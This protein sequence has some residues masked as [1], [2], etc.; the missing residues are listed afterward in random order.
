MKA[1]LIDNIRVMSARDMKK[2]MDG[3]R[4]DYVLLDVRQPEEYQAGH[5]PGAISIPLGE[6][7]HRYRELEKSKKIIA[8]CR[9]GRRSKGASLLLRG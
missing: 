1:R 7:E 6:L 8:L 4:K 9:S 3:K 5:I 2:V